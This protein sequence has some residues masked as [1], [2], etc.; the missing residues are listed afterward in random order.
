MSFS[1]TWP[2]ATVDD[3][4]DR[5]QPPEPGTG[6]TVI[7]RD[8][9][10]LTAKNSGE[11]WVIIELEGIDGAAAQ[12]QW[13][14]LQGFKS[15]QQAGFT[16]RVVRDLGVDIDSISGASIEELDQA[17]KPVIGQYFSVDVVQNGD[18]RNTYFRGPAT[19]RQDE[20][21]AAAVSGGPGSAV[22][23]DGTTIP[24]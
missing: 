17:L 1:D 12:H 22:D 9:K 15:A 3:Q 11:D 7:V 4:P 2:N 13:A 19:V 16:K 14:V 20:L 18:Y 21:P 5:T 8:A 24:F 23:D 10:A 6:Y